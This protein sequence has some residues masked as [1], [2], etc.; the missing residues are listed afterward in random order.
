MIAVQAPTLRSGQHA[1]DVPLAVCTVGQVN[2]G[3][4]V[5]A[6]FSACHHT[7]YLHFLHIGG[8]VL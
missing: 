6:D 7:A 5:F 1:G 3:G 4:K 8:L 2:D